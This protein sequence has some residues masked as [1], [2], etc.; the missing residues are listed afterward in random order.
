M[1]IY[2]CSCLNPLWGLPILLCSNMCL[3]LLIFSKNI[4]VQYNHL[5]VDWPYCLLTYVYLHAIHL[6]LCV[7]LLD[8][9][10]IIVAV[11]MIQRFVLVV[12]TVQNQLMCFPPGTNK[13][14]PFLEPV[15]FIVSPGSEHI[16]TQ[17]SH[18]ALDIATPIVSRDQ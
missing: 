3:M 1:N 17:L 11:S 12:I 8:L 7:K 16:Y 4:R 6:L 18:W 9:Q 2:G 13:A 5:V 15:N 10:F 14:V